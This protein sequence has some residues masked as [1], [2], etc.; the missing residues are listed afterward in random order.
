MSGDCDHERVDVKL[1][2]SATGYVFRGD[3][4]NTPY[5]I[6]IVLYGKYGQMEAGC[7]EDVVSTCILVP[8]IW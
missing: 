1:R 6:K 2:K 8:G 4:T 5:R 3:G 7:V